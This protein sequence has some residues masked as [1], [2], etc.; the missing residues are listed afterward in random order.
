MRLVFAGTPAIAVPSL[1]AIIEAGHEVVAVA[2]NP[3]APVGRYRRLTS[4]PVAEAARAH[5]LETLTPARA[6]DPEFGA[7]LADMAPEVCAIVAWGQLIPEALLALPPHGWI[8]LHFSLLPAWRG[9]APVQRA[10]M[11]GET[12]TG[13]TTFRLVKELDAGAVFRQV[14]TSISPTETAGEVLA[15]LAALGAG[16]LLDTLSDLE[17][18]VEPTPQSTT[19]I[20][21]APKVSVDDARIDWAKDAV[22][23]DCLVRGTSP[24]PGAWTTWGEARLRVLR[25]GHLPGQHPR[26]Q[27]PQVPGVGV[28]AHRVVPGEHLRR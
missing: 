28:P 4:S 1:E 27:A 10:L 24:V 15:R 26:Q 23:L 7:R 5:G 3:D 18:G 20:T 14:S 2:T 9:A 16:V 22:G 13:V 8:N 21:L 19:G 17:S 6:R 11:A 12:T 25:T